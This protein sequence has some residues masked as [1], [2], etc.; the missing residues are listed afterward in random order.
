MFI[1][2]AKTNN[3]SKCNSNFIN[4][5]DVIVYFASYVAENFLM[6]PNGNIFLFTVDKLWIRK[7]LEIEL[8][9]GGTC[10]GSSILFFMT[11]GHL[12]S[13][14]VFLVTFVALKLDLAKWK[15]NNRQQHSTSCLKWIHKILKFPVFAPLTKKK[16]YISRLVFLRT[17]VRWISLLPYNY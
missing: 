1:C 16:E 2:V 11:I 17:A 3:S 4:V 6:S 7:K 8:F 5:A 10:F 13:S 12:D 14:F 15:K 9:Y